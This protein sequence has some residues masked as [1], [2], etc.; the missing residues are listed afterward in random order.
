MLLRQRRFGHRLGHGHTIRR[1]RAGKV[2]SDP[3]ERRTG[4]TPRGEPGFISGGEQL[5][6]GRLFHRRAT[7]IR[8]HQVRSSAQSDVGVRPATDG[9]EAGRRG[10]PRPTWYCTVPVE[11]ESHSRQRTDKSLPCR[12][13]VEYSIIRYSSKL[14]G[15]R[16]V[17]CRSAPKPFGHLY[18]NFRSRAR[19]V[20]PTDGPADRAE[21]NNLRVRPAGPIERA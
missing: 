15:I 16:K 7:P 9:V 11:T 12:V 6:R 2:G 13:R 3:P 20:L 4:P 18:L 1:H 19:C 17:E 8:M 14:L 21:R 5:S 10:R